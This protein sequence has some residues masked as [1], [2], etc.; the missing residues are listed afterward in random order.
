MGWVVSGALAAFVVTVLMLN[1]TGGEKRIEH[2]IPHAQGVRDAQFQREIGTLLGPPVL[3]GNSIR[4]LENGD[5]IFPAML[6]AIRGARHSITFET[7]I[8]WSGSIGDEFAVALSERA[9]A[10]VKVHVLLDWVGSQKIDDRM[11]ASLRA[12]GVQVE[13]FHPLRWYS[14]GRIN[15]RTHRKLLVVDGQVGFT[16]GVGIADLWSGSASD[17]QHWR[18]SHYELRGPA[19]AQMQAAFM[20]NWIKA[21]GKV[22]SGPAYFPALEPAGGARA[23]VFVASPDGGGDSM[24][25]MYLMAIGAAR[26]TID[27]SASYFV[28]DELTRGVLLDALRRGVKV[29]II[30]PGSNIDTEVVRKASRAEWGQLLAAGAQIFEYQPTMFH[31]KMLVVDRHLVSVGS[32]NFDNRSFRLNEEANLNIYDDAFAEHVTGVFEA[33]LRHARRITYEQWQQRPWR[34][35]LLEHTAALFSSQL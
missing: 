9:R 24:M 20:D 19:V 18:D 13:L 30:V 15:N 29:R 27:L 1:F 8:Y 5:T 35:K 4:N 7:Y 16:G 10:G 34:E 12:A 25:L 31:C 26:Q 11:L 2:R 3:A 28:P 22:L 23:Q 14:L 33:D 32:T 21:T 17:P 6:Q